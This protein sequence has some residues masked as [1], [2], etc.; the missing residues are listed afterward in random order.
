MRPA[1]QS[2]ELRYTQVFQYQE[3]SKLN[4]VYYKSDN[5]DTPGRVDTLDTFER[6]ER[7]ENWKTRHKF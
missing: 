5:F 3:K 4:D 6:S 7:L 1:L 2:V